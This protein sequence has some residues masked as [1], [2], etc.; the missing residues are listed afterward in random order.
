[1]SLEIVIRDYGTGEGY[2]EMLP[3]IVDLNDYISIYNHTRIYFAGY[4]GS[5]LCS[6]NC[7]RA[8]SERYSPFIVVVGE[9]WGEYDPLFISYMTEDNVSRKITSEDKTFEIVPQ[10]FTSITE[11]DEATHDEYC[12]DMTEYNHCSVTRPYR[13]VRNFDSE[14]QV[15]Y[16]AL[17]YDTRVCGP[18][19]WLTY[20]EGCLNG[21]N[22][23]YCDS[24]RNSA[25]SMECVNEKW[26]TTKDEDCDSLNASCF[27]ES[28]EAP[29]CYI[30]NLTEKC[31]DGTSKGACAP[32]KPKYCTDVG[33]LIDSPKVCGCPSNAR[34][35]VTT[36]TCLYLRCSD[37]TEL[38]RCSNSLPYYCSNDAVLIEKSSECGC[39]G[40]YTPQNEGCMIPAAP[41]QPPQPQQIEENITTNIS[42]T[43]NESNVTQPPIPSQ[44]PP[45]N[46][47]VVTPKTN[48]SLPNQTKNETLPI[49]T[50]PEATEISKDM[51]YG[52][53]IVLLVAVVAYMYLNQP[54]KKA[55]NKH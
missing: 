20:A 52:V 54:S 41:Q 35:D 44:P 9:R 45:N 16:Y 32:K 30:R 28:G 12:S 39:P 17:E 25:V 3:Q 53:V 10:H 15:Y 49:N 47:S 34:Y 18:T 40:G 48:E 6:T 4:N 38:L 1:M 36:N 23:S 8:Y 43:V 55:R 22:K 31:V 29:Y 7:G 2:T 42:S 5:K 24:Y 14:D 26:T 46:A 37:D 50:P 13:C 51:I 11:C 27:Q 21:A 33:V 19:P